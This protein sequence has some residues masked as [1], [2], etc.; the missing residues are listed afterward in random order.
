MLNIMLVSDICKKIGDSAQEKISSRYHLFS[1]VLTKI[2]HIFENS[3]N[4][5]PYIPINMRFFLVMMSVMLIKAVDNKGGSVRAVTNSKRKLGHL[6][7]VY[8]H[9]ER[10]KTAFVNITENT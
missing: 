1:I 4:K 6:S 9:L 10:R 8:I 2:W 3:R 5:V 7:F